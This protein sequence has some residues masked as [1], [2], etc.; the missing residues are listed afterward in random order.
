[1]IRYARTLVVVVL[2]AATVPSFAIPR[3]GGPVEP[4]PIQRIVRM[5]RHFI[6]SSNSDL[7]S[8]PKP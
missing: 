5:I 1:M 7:M 8:V 2:L 6:S 3:D 4:N